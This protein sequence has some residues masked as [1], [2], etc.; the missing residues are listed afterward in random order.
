MHQFTYILLHVA[1][2]PGLLTTALWGQL[3]IASGIAAGTGDCDSPTRGTAAVA[4][5]QA[6]PDKMTVCAITPETLPILEITCNGRD[7]DVTVAH[8]QNVAL[9]ISV[10]ARG[11]AGLDVDLWCFART[12][13]GAHYC[14]NGICWQP[15]LAQPYSTGPLHNLDATILD[16]TLPLGGYLAYIALD[17]IPNGILDRSSV[18]IYDVV[19]FEVLTL[20]GFFEDFEDCIANDWVPDGPDWVVGDGVY[21]LDCSSSDRFFSFFEK[22]DY[23][24]FTYSGDLKM[25]DTGD[26]NATYN[27]GI[28]FRSTPPS[29]PSDHRPPFPYVDSGYHVSFNNSSNYQCYKA[30]LGN[31]TT[32]L[33]SGTSPYLVAGVGIWNSVTV[34]VRGSQIDIYFNGILET[35]VIESSYTIGKVGLIGEGSSTYD[36]DYEF[37]N[38]ALSLQ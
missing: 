3:Q 28:F 34:D 22:F 36:L 25:V 21:Y 4:I 10:A 2:L 15:G 30:K 19:D 5:D 29:T 35:T 32:L 38:V 14:H 18:E 31:S 6:T 16:I 37:D 23:A 11:Y 12:S 20:T 24:D 13:A 9:K 26:P 1:V 7:A 33:A 17:P 27:C 8:N